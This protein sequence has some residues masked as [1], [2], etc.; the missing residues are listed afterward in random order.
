MKTFLALTSLEEAIDYIADDIV[1]I[2]NGCLKKKEVSE[3]YKCLDRP[4]RTREEVLVRIQE[5]SEVYEKIL[6]ELSVKLNEIHGLNLSIEAWRPILHM[7]LPYYVEE[8]YIKY[9][10]VQKAMVDYTCLYTNILDEDSFIHPFYGYGSWI[11]SLKREDY[12]FQLY[13]HVAQFM[14]LE[15]K[16]KINLK[17]GVS[18]TKVP[19]KAGSRERFFNALGQ[20]AKTIIINPDQFGFSVA[21]LWKII[22]KSNFKIG[23]FFSES[24]G[25]VP[26]EYDA[27]FRENLKLSCRADDSE[28]VR[29]I[30][31]YVFAD[32]PTMYLEGFAESYA[33]L[34]KYRCEKIISTEEYPFHM[35]ALLMG[36]TKKDGGKLYTVP[37]GGD[38]NVWQGVP[39]ARMDALIS[40]VLY[41]TGWT[42]NSYNCELRKITNPRYWRARQNVKQEEKKCDILYLASATFAYCTI[43]SNVNGIYSKEFMDDNI[44]LIRSLVSNNLRIRARFF[45]YTGWNLSDRIRALGKNA[46]ID[47]YGRKF[48]ETVLESKLCVM[49][50]FGTAWAEA[51]AMNI[52]FIIIIPK[53]ME[54]FTE[55]GWK[56]VHRLQRIGMYFN[57]HQEAKKH[58]LSIIDDVESWW[59]DSERQ[60]VIAQIGQEYA[61]CAKDAKKEWIDEFVNISRE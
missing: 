38:G 36:K 57:D 25:V 19:E 39:E 9:L 32:I 49:D 44:S 29:L 47:D 28:F 12:N 56:L 55:A 5:S 10:H 58:I 20:R 1:Y 16:N 33:L 61:W 23:F 11:W 59:L 40:D 51:L 43:M 30:K 60:K 53:Y 8:M 26:K 41:T 54:F 27:D 6:M 22:I 31:T 50:S 52:P 21:E 42:D 15:V 48:I 14:Q 35:A 17:Q 45:A 18:S 37:I 3:K 34:N 46:E 2:E 13:S 4:F 24:M 7:W